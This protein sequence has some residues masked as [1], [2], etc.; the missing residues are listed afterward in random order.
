M[1]A[2]AKNVLESLRGGEWLCGCGR[3]LYPVYDQDGKK[4]GVTHTP[5]DEDW[6]LE[7]FAG[8][9]VERISDVVSLGG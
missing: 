1:K 8:I 3:K 4:V 6:H 5:E 7:Y 2:K 9:H